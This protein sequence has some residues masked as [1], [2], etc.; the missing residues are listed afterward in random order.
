[1]WV[2]RGVV[3]GMVPS[4]SRLW[5]RLSQEMASSPHPP[6]S[7][8]SPRPQ[9]SSTP[10]PTHTTVPPS[11]PP[12]S[13]PS[14]STSPPLHQSSTTIVFNSYKY[15]EIIDILFI[16]SYCYIHVADQFNSAIIMCCIRCC[17]SMCCI[18][19]C[20]SI[21]IYVDAIYKVHIKKISKKS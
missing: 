20:A 18:L 14:P 11:P 21:I 6:P 5:R 12:S 13:S 17:A 15:V 1:M 7:S 4:I 19:C 8:S 3:M 9:P 16:A 10:A 2:V